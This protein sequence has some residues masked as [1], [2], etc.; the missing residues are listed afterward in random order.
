MKIKKNIRYTV[1]NKIPYNET[2]FTEKR[3][4]I[5]FSQNGKIAV[6]RIDRRHRNHCAWSDHQ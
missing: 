5:Y 3:N 4:Q 6:R 2:A 1:E